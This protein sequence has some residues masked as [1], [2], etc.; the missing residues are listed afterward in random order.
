MQTSTP[1]ST[2]PNVRLQRSRMRPGTLSKTRA[3][4]TNPSRGRAPI[5]PSTARPDLKGA[6]ST[7][8][9]TPTIKASRTSTRTMA[10][11]CAPGFGTTDRCACTTNGRCHPRHCHRRCRPR[12]LPRHRRRRRLACSGSLP[13][14]SSATTTSFCTPSWTWRSVGTRP[15]PTRSGTR[16]TLR[17]RVRGTSPSRGHC[18]TPTRS[19]AT[20]GPRGVSFGLGP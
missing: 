13:S 16:P 17:A 20:R 4:G 8:G 18:A 7:K 15:T 14:M 10:R 11:L 12:H 1:F 5:R 3:R 9:C 19:A 6:S 2:S